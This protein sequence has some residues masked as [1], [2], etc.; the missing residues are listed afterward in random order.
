MRASRA[1]EEEVVASSSSVGEEQRRLV[2]ASRAGKEKGVGYY[3]VWGLRGEGLYARFARGMD[4]VVATTS[5]LFE[6][7]CNPLRTLFTCNP[8]RTHRHDAR[9]KVVCYFIV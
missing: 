3:I 2:C 6:Y 9:G 1:G 8:L 4:E 7:T 5:S